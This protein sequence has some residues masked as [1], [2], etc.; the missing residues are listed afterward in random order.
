MRLNNY[1]KKAETYAKHQKN[2]GTLILAYKEFGALFKK[3]IT[4]NGNRAID[5]GSGTGRS[6]RY[7]QEVGFDAE[8]VDI[9]ESMLEK[10]IELDC[11]NH[12]RYKLI[13]DSIIPHRKSKY[14]LAFSSLVVLE[15]ASK[16]ELKKYFSEAYRVMKFDGTLIVLT[17]NDDFYKYQWTSV[18]TNYPG[19]ID[20]KSGDKVRIR[21]KEINLEL[22]DYYWTKEDYR[23]IA[24]SC[25]LTVVE[26]VEPTGTK[27]D[28]VE[29]ISEY[30][31]SPYVIFVMKKTC[32]LENKNRIA[33]SQGLDINI[34]GRG[35]FKEIHRSS[36][37]VKDLPAEYSGDRNESATIRLLMT[38]GDY[39]PF[40]KLKSKE[41]FTHVEGNDVLIHCINDKG[42][43]SCI[44]LGEEHE[45]AVKNYIIPSNCWYAEEVVGNNGYALVEAKTEPAF[46]PADQK[47]ATQEEL[48]SLVSPQNYEAL[49]VIYKK[50]NVNFTF[51]SDGKSELNDSGK[52]NLSNTFPLG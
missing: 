50:C 47:E 4:T 28:G 14:D 20:A 49:K 26:E 42:D 7:L 44:Y 15:L 22:D 27:G 38:P 13:K 48:V 51:F 19:N 35:I 52:V 34:P 36:T 25:G 33:L 43:Y 45:N 41:T 16:E 40:H 10:S 24:N 29:W 9:D 2:E 8:G 37:I 12:E 18:D 21:I 30:E 39:W 1:E 3:Y 23:E 31:H 5:I 46:D 6:T 17:V 11:G 32:A